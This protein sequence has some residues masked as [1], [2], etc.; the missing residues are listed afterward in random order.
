MFGMNERTFR[1]R[2]KAEGVSLRELENE[3]R[4]E[5]SC[6]L[7]RDTSLSVLSIANILGFSDGQVFARAFRLWMKMSPSTWRQQGLTD[8]GR[9]ELSA[10]KPAISI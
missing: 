5:L 2:L 9:A 4:C 1:R 6:Q 3:V 8:I 10:R 7:L